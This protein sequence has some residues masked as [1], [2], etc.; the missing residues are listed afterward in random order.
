MRIGLDF[1]GT[2]A[3]YDRV[4]HRCAMEQ[5]GLP[6]QISPSKAAIRDWFWTTP[7]GKEQWIELQAQVYGVQIHEAT[8]AVGLGEFLQH[9]RQRNIHVAIISH[10][11]EFAARGPRVN[12]RQAAREWLEVQGFYDHIARQDV[13]FESTRAEKIQRI[14][15]FGCSRF[16]DDLEEVFLEP[17][18][19]ESV[20]KLLYSTTHHNDSRESIKVFSSWDSIRQYFLHS[21][22]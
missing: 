2:I 20:E 16:V 8:I 19:P 10:K 17:A 1:D 22:S 11:T 15:S 6:N 14:S 21:S 7:K 4:F 5:F 13:F 12:L 3:I 9:C 18:F